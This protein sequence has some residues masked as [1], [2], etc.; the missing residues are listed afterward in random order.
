MEQELGVMEIICTAG[1]AR[2]LSYEALR[3]A[4]EHNFE[5][6][7]EKVVHARAC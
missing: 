6:A 3:V 1:E 5:A 7:E 4:R 2:S